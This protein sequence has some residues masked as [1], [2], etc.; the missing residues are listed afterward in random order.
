MIGGSSSLISVSMH[1]PGHLFAELRSGRHDVGG[2][3][4]DE[5]D[6]DEEEEEDEEYDEERN[7]MRARV[8]RLAAQAAEAA[9]ARRP[10]YGLAAAAETL[11]SRP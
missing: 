8:N 6:E 7:R 1:G 4:R 10:Y 3:V 11:N 9:E 5:E 2:W